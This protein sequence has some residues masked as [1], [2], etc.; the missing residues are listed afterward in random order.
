MELYQLR[1]F[2][3]IAQAGNVTQAAGA[4]HVTQSTASGHLKGLESELGAA[5]FVRSAGGVQLTEFGRQTLAKAQVVLNAADELLATARL[6]G[7]QLRLAV[8]NEAETL[9]LGA[10]MYGLRTNYPQVNVSIDHGLSGWALA[11]VKASRHDAGFYMGKLDDMEVRD[12]RIRMV[13]YCIAG[14]IAWREKV[15]AERWKAVGDLPWIWVPPMGSYPR[16]VTELLAR[17]GVR[18]NKV[19]ETDRES[20]TRNL[21]SAG[22]GLCLLREELA[23]QMV[24]QGDIFIWDEG[25]TEA[26]LSI[27]YLAD[28]EEEPI[29]QA[30][31]NVVRSVIA[32]P[33]AGG[34]DATPSEPSP[35]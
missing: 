30:L 20:T 5:L 6:Q 32:Q 12:L 3:A 19:I 33:L 28:R 17:H 15:L 18:P 34:A 1:T 29:I 11:E 2:V 21:A 9:G 24:R 13:R 14:P 25:R 8:V 4:L 26:P 35:P 10:I 23:Q 31:L 27:I 22:V 16:L 7:G